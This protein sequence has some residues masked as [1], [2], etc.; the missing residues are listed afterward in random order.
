[1]RARAPALPAIALNIILRVFGPRV[2]TELRIAI[3]SQR[4]YRLRMGDSP[5]E[6]WML[7]PKSPLSGR[8]HE[9]WGVSPRI[10]S[11]KAI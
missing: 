10:V 5:Y 11:G 1:M 9:A 6:T 2:L 3:Q 4:V 8:Q 7:N